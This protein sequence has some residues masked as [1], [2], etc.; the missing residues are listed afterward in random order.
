MD[1]SRLATGASVE[2]SIVGPSVVLG[3]GAS[4]QDESVVGEGA[5]IDPGATVGNGARIEAGEGIA[6]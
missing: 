4:V 2:D 1:G 5:Y 3:F 6:A